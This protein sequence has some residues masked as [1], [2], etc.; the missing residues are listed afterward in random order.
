LIWGYS[1]TW[2]FL[3]DRAK[4]MVY[5]HFGMETRRHQRFLNRV[6]QVIAPHVDNEPHDYVGTNLHG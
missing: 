2:A 6:K 3:T 4:V 1:V 5:R